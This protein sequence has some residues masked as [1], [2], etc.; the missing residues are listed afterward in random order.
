MKENEINHFNTL[1]ADKG[2]AWWGSKTFSG[3]LRKKKRA[4]FAKKHVGDLKGKN[5]LE[6]GC[7]S[8][9][10]TKYLAIEFP[11]SKITA[12]DISPGQIEIARR[13]VAS[14]EFSVDD[15]EA[16]RFPDGTFDAVIANSILHHVDTDTCLKE[17]LRVLK[18]GGAAFFTEPNMLNPEVFLEKKIG[19]FRKKGQHSP[20]ETAFYRWKV[21]KALERAGFEEIKA[22]NFDF[23]HPLVPRG[24]SAVFY[25]LSDILQNIPVIKEISGSLMIFGR[26]PW[27]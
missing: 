6:I 2:Y 4:E 27:R 19:W 3:Q 13:A 9:D 17:C 25:F 18:K 23:L 26:K 1:A 10:Y 8:G 24:L 14:V 7:A 5:I 16:M 21:R 15:C 12:T 20:D 22:R 11:E